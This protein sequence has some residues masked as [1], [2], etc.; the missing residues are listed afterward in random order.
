MNV[1]ITSNTTFDKA[2][3]LRLESLY[4]VIVQLELR[5]G[6]YASCPR[7]RASPRARAGVGVQYA[8]RLRLY[9]II[10]QGAEFPIV[11]ATPRALSLALTLGQGQGLGFSMQ[12]D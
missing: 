12:I 11:T 8:N 9:S 6:V 5:G 10:V 4:T 7:S 2:N 1:R 3:R